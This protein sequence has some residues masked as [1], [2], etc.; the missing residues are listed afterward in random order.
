MHLSS[1]KI[2]QKY[3]VPIRNIT[4]KWDQ[5]YKLPQYWF[6]KK[7]AI[8]GQGGC[9]SE[10]YRYPFFMTNLI[11]CF[12]MWHQSA[13][14]NGLFECVEKSSGDCRIIDSNNV[15]KISPWRIKDG[16]FLPEWAFW[17]I[18]G[19]PDTWIATKSCVQRYQHR[20]EIWFKG[21][22]WSIWKD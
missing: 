13:S 9:F 3:V 5:W 1:L 8:D 14:V 18:T 19:I 7:Y 15:I 10:W 4:Q 22:N 11:L 12:L 20:Y 17:V 6:K 21:A 2:L 16:T